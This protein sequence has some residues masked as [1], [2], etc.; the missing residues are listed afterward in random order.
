ML[1]LGV[2]F[3]KAAYQKLLPL[4]MIIE[5]SASPLDVAFIVGHDFGLPIEGNPKILY[6]GTSGWKKVITKL[7]T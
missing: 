5:F 7:L 1:S 3:S 4:V 2:N 6:L